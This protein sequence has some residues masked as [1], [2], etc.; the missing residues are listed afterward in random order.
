M[1]STGW[2]GSY[3]ILGIMALFVFGSASAMRRAQARKE[4]EHRERMKALE[5]GLVP[6]PS[7]LDWPAAAV[8]IALGAGVPVGSFL[9]AW[10]AALTAGA[11][12][13]IW[14]APVFVSF[15]AIG[16]SR[17]LASRIIDPRPASRRDSF[18]RQ[19][20]PAAKPAFDPDSFD[21]V[22]ARG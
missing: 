18:A 15:A 9:V 22:G 3:A 20:N 14:V 7:G 2:D 21:V 17:K 6:Q 10:L 13:G 1:H 4:M 5:V 12:D 19:G 8:C 16:A 11:P